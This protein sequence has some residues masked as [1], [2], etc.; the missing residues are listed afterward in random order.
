MRCGVWGVCVGL[1][2]RIFRVCLN[3]PSGAVRDTNFLPSLSRYVETRKIRSAS[4]P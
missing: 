4:M 1:E 2:R 3:L